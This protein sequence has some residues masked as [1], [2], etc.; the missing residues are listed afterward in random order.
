MDI[1][2][3]MNNKRILL[4]ICNKLMFGCFLG[5]YIFLEE[6]FFFWCECKDFLCLYN[7]I[8]FFVYIKW[9]VWVCYFGELGSLELVSY[10]FLFIVL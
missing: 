9:D 3:V 6:F 4:F 5:Y 8:S 2:L 10:V 7:K 1:S